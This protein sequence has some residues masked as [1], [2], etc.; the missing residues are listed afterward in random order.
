MSALTVTI[1]ALL[2]APGVVAFTG[3]RIYPVEAPEG[4]PFPFII[5][6]LI[7]EPTDQV[8]HGVTAYYDSRVQ[9][10]CTA[11]TATEANSMGEAVKAALEII[12]KASIAGKTDVDI[13]KEA[14]DYSDTNDARTVKRRIMDFRV[15]WR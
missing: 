5:V 3:Q 14:S 7:G 2:A 8:L 10:G 6:N 15:R 4:A 12:E 11:E 1:S 9:I 13:S